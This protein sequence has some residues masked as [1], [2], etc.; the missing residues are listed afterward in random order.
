MG[1]PPL[2]GMGFQIPMPS[3]SEMS[4]YLGL[5]ILRLSVLIFAALFITYFLYPSSNYLFAII[6][7]LFCILLFLPSFI[8]L[9]LKSKENYMSWQYSIVHCFYLISLFLIYAIIF[10][11]S[12]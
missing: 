9:F 11:I 5:L 6:S 8:T 4:R 10:K 12:L 1:G 7:W 2:K 3:A